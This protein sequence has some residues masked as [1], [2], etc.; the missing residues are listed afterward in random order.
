MGVLYFDILDLAEDYFSEARPRSLNA[1]STKPLSGLFYYFYLNAPLDSSQRNSS[2]DEVCGLGTYLFH[3]KMT[4]STNGSR[5][6][7]V[8]FVVISRS[9][10]SISSPSE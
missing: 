8:S 3:P 10:P 6:L 7:Q 9:F 5:Y 2:L 4:E 1:L